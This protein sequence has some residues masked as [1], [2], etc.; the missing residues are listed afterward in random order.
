MDLA[1]FSQ[2][3]TSPVLSFTS[4][5][6]SML[7]T[8]ALS[9]SSS[10]LYWLF[11]G[12]MTEFRYSISASLSRRGNRTSPLC[13]VTFA[14]RTPN[15]P[16]LSY[17]MSSSEAPI[18]S[19]AL[20]II[21]GINGSSSAAHILMVSKR[22]YKT[23]ASLADFA[24]SFANIQGAVSSIYLLARDTTVIISVR[25]KES[26]V[27]SIYFSTAGASFSAIALRFASNS[28]SSRS[29]GNV[30]SKYFT[31]IATVLETRLPKSLARSEFMRFIIISLE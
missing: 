25:A 13:T 10:S 6:L 21:V 9:K 20:G 19:K 26:L 11:W 27:S 12:A 17:L 15:L 3:V 14:G 1:T 5:N 22:L 18:C 24:G 7:I 30:P 2:D 28:P 29:V 23:V 4:V 8:F 31:A 16:K